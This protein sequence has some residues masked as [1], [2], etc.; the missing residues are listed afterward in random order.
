MPLLLDTG[1][2][3]ALAD[4]KEPDHKQVKSF[5]EKT[6]EFLILPWVIVPELAYLLKERL[7]APAE[8]AFLRSLNRQEFVLQEMDEVDLVRAEQILAD[9]PD[10]GMVDSVVMAIAERL[11]IQKIVTFDHRDYRR[12]RP[13]HCDAFILLP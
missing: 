6:R 9:Y 7:G 12:F 2:L 11:K 4:K 1:P 13:L 5:F 3:Y 10:F 8:L